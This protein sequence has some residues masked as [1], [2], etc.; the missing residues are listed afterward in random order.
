MADR[1]DIE[2]LRGPMHQ[3]TLDE[4]LALVEAVQAAH[5][6]L[7]EVERWAEQQNDPF[8]FAGQVQ[9]WALSRREKL[10]ARFRFGDEQ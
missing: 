5:R 2:A 3:P 6:E 4:Q 1:I 9:H 10:T 8:G 7:R